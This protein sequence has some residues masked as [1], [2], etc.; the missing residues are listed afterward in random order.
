MDIDFF[1]VMFNKSTLFIKYL[2]KM[3]ICVMNKG[4]I[5]GHEVKVSMAYTSRFSEF[6]LYL[7]DYLMYEHLGLG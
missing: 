7:E 6:A 2:Q 3:V 1:Q 5:I 4:H